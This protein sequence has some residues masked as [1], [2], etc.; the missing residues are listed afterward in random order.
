MPPYII[1]LDKK[2]GKKLLQEMQKEQDGYRKYGLTDEQKLNADKAYQKW[3]DESEDK[4]NL[5][6]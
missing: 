6:F 2:K 1:N 4:K 3:L 5:P